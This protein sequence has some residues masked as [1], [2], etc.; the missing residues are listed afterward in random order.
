MKPKLGISACLLGQAVRYDGGHKLDN[1]V[2]DALGRNFEF[3]AVC[4]EI[5]S[6]MTVP[7]EPMRLEGDPASLRLITTAGRVDKTDQME[8]WAQTYIV[9]LE[10]E[11]LTGFV[12]KSKS[13][14]CGF[15]VRV[16]N[17]RGMVVQKTMGIFA[18][19]FTRRFPSLPVAE[20]EMLHN[21]P[22]RESFIARLLLH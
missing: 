18:R 1:L 12:F 14:S 20:A 17:S 9:K 4:P 15:T 19:S 21:A 7:R 6:G 2:I 16:Y 11:N 3:V 8:H 22:F 10:N 5:G 13:P